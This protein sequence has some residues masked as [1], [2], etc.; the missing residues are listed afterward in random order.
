MVFKF[1]F[2]NQRRLSNYYNNHKILPPWELGQGLSSSSY[3]WA[4]S[5]KRFNIWRFFPHIFLFLDLERPFLFSDLG[6]VSF[7]ILHFENYFNNL[8]IRVF[9]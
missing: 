4:P 8:D 5:E 1:K 7:Q 6:A 9:N 3:I 2:G